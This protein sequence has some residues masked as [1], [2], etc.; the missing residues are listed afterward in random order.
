MF[1]CFGRFMMRLVLLSLFAA[2]VRFSADGVPG[3]RHSLRMALSAIV[4]ILVVPSLARA[5]DGLAFFESKVR[6]LLEEHCLEC[7]GGGKKV[8][9][10]LR[11]SHRGGWETGGDS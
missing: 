9:G 4:F 7:H 6:P 8:K 3:V 1:L 10:G 11:L 2:G 5:D